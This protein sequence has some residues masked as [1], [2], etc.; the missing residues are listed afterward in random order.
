MCVCVCVCRGVGV[1]VGGA[2]SPWP[3]QW[4]RPCDMTAR[5]DI[6]PEKLPPTPRATYYHSLRVH[7]EVS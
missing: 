3:P 1:G 2:W 7:L 5:G 6:Q 4:L